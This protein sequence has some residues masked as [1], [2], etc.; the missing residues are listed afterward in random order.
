MSV[1]FC[2][3]TII[4]SS[5]LVNYLMPIN[6]LSVCSEVFYQVSERKLQELCRIDAG[7]GEEGA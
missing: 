7:L 5:R 1:V 6:V 4:I 3:C 2:L